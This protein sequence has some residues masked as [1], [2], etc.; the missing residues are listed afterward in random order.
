MTTSTK[1]QTQLSAEGGRISDRTPPI[2]L[3]D[4]P[5]VVKLSFN[6]AQHQ[7]DTLKKIASAR[8]VTMTEVLR[9]AI[10]LEDFMQDEVAQKSRIFIEDIRGNRKELA[11]MG[12]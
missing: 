5:P 9:H 2:E 12:P 11:L 3:P 6:L 8:G 7:V 10:A 1:E 4:R